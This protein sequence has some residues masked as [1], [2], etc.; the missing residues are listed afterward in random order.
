MRDLRVILE[1]FELKWETSNGEEGL[2]KLIQF[3]LQLSCLR[4]VQIDMLRSENTETSK[5][6]HKKSISN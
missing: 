5:Q 3:D 2:H 4:A 1:I 6:T